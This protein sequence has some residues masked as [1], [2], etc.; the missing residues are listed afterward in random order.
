MKLYKNK[1]SAGATPLHKIASWPEFRWP[2]LLLALAATGLVIAALFMQHVQELNPCEQCIYQ[3]T[4]MIGIA[5]F[6][7]LGF[8]M[9]QLMLARI[10]AY[11][12]WLYSAWAGYGSAAH[13]LWLQRDA[14]PLFHSCAAIPSFPSWAPL[15]EWLPSV[16][17]ITGVCGDDGWRF[18]SLN[19]P[20]WM[21]IIFAIFLAIGVITLLIRIV[22]ARR[23]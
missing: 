10:V 18:L 7:W 22:Y 9:P 16:F 4:A 5:L 8:F 12:G 20:E 1:M 19:M 2:W 3:R 21:R 17:A 15:H 14:N 6:A 11:A 13:H 23:I